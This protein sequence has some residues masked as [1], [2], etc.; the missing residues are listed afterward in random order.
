MF[1]YLYVVFV[2]DEECKLMV[3]DVKFIVE[4]VCKF[5]E[6]GFENLVYS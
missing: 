2:F 5:N 1:F 4:K 6:K 3:E